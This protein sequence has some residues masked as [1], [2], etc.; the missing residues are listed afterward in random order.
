MH[1][2]ATQQD[3]EKQTYPDGHPLD[4]IHYLECKIILKPDRFTSAHSFH[5][6]GK[7]VRHAAAEL[8]IA[9]STDFVAGQKPRIRE[10][11]FFDTPDFRLY[12]NAFILRR[13][14]PYLDGFPTD[15]AEVVIKFRH[16]D[17][18]AAAKIDVRPVIQGGYRIKFKEEL[19]PPHDTVGGMR[20]LYSHNC[21]FS[22]SRQHDERRLQMTTV[23]HAIPALAPLMKNEA[24]AIELV[25]H[26]AVEEV[27]LDL[28]ELHFGHGVSAL[29]N[30]ALWRARADHAPLVG[31][32]A[33]QCKFERR[34]E[35]HGKSR[36]QCEQFFLKLQ[37]VAGDWLS[38]GTTK[39]GIVYQLNGNPPQG[40]E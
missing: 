2:K 31:E 18:D 1:G 40:H 12:N 25:N 13:R 32:F 39:T 37:Q 33:Y 4:E 3:E 16:P 17:K 10:V 14:I 34:N 20:S 11:L 7:L 19:L 9:Y 38:L 6:F 22:L 35:L 23:V 30:V 5:D 21:V 15:P 8:E 26:T 24:E 27:L 36:K 28:G 29:A